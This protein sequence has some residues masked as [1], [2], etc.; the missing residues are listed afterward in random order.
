M[1]IIRAQ[2]LHAADHNPGISL[3]AEMCR[4]RNDLHG[5][6][7]ADVS[8]AFA[9][10]AL[11]DSPHGGVRRQRQILP[12]SNTMTAADGNHWNA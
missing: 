2:K 6:H 1:T 5:D 7:K 9:S 4:N 3:Q 11:N 12:S 8:Q 10:F